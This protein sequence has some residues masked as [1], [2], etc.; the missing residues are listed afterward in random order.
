M[1]FDKGRDTSKITVLDE[2]KKDNKKI[3]SDGVMIPQIDNDINSTDVEQ[4]NE[5]NLGSNLKKYYKIITRYRNGEFGDE[6][7]S[8]AEILNAA[9]EMN[10]LNQMNADEI[11]YLVKNSF[12]I[13]KMMFLEIKKKN[14]KR[15]KGQKLNFPSNK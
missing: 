7:L 3:S 5:N 11:Q 13:T 10:L 8:F 14:K 2:V 15:I 12:G 6:N 4:N 1:G 9:G